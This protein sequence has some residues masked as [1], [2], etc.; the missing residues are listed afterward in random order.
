MKSSNYLFIEYK[1]LSKEGKLL[2]TVWCN[3]SQQALTDYINDFRRLS[4]ERGKKLDFIEYINSFGKHR[5]Y[6]NLQEVLRCEKKN[7][8]VKI[9]NL[10]RK[11]NLC[12]V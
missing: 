10:N 7:T 5:A 4:V 2:F 6:D 11:S 1:I 9:P 12:P 3:A 8:M